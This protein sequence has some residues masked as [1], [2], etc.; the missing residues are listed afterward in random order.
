MCLVCIKYVFHTV[1]INQ[2]TQNINKKIHYEIIESIA[3]VEGML[4][5]ENAILYEYFGKLLL[6]SS[7]VSQCVL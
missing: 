6:L 3:G 7:R 1:T 4:L 5:K 2:S